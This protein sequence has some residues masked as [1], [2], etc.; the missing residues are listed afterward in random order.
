MRKPSFLARLL[1][2]LVAILVLAGS[3]AAAQGRTTPPGPPVLCPPPVS[4]C[5]EAEAIEKAG[6][7]GR[8]KPP[9]TKATEQPATP[10][11]PPAT[12]SGSRP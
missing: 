4:H 3:P 10:S 5:P 1:I 12:S 2:A 7:R 8:A 9:S 11:Q 6:A